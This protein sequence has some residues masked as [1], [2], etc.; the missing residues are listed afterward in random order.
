MRKAGEYLPRRAN[1]LVT[2][3]LADTRVS[4]GDALTCLPIS[5]LWTTP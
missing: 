5:A 4:F 2:E 3:A 1:D